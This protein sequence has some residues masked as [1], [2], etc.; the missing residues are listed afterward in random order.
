MICNNCGYTN[1][2]GYTGLCRSCRKP[3]IVEAVEPVKKT[4]V[5][6]EKKSVAKKKSKQAESEKTYRGY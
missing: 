1:P 2:N 3:L 6:V 5:A 4:T